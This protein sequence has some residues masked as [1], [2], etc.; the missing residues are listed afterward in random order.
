MPTREDEAIMAAALMW[1]TATEEDTSC[2]DELDDEDPPL[3]GATDPLHP[4]YEGVVDYEYE[5]EEDEDP[6]FGAIVKFSAD[7]ADYEGDDYDGCYYQTGSD[8][9]WWYVT[10]VVDCDSGGF[11]EDLV[12][13]HGPFLTQEEAELA[14]RDVA[15]G[16]CL[17][18]HVTWRL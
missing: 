1:A 6:L 11:V 3:F 4:D 15:V 16:W 10:V 7:L 12:T 5:D 9:H 2:D 8:G 18:N 13:D 14:G 17:D